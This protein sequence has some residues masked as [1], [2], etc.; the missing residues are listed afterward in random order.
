M[1][2]GL[3]R[4]DSLACE[5]CSG[6]SSHPF[7]GLERLA[8]LKTCSLNRSLR[9]D[10]DT[11]R[12]LSCMPQVRAACTCPPRSFLVTS[13]PLLRDNCCAAKASLS[14]QLL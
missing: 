14:H 12:S 9:V 6:L 1:L 4:L 11:C 8:S 7:A 10:D 3:S 5:G 2:A 13:N